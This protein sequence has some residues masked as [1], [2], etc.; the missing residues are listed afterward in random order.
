[1]V[2]DFGA[3]F[4]SFYSA[5]YDLRNYM[6]CKG[7]REEGDRTYWEPQDETDLEPVSPA[8]GPGAMRVGELDYSEF[9][10]DNDEP[11]CCFDDCDEF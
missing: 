4:D 10:Q 5:R 2:S 1:M 9:Y 8:Y 3:R 6:E 7:Y 11:S